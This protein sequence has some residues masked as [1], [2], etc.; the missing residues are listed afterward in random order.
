[1]KKLTYKDMQL[2]KIYEICWFDH[3]TTE[4]KSSEQ[5]VMKE[6]TILRSYG[7]YIG[8]NKRYIILAYNFENEISENNDNIHI[9]KKEIQN[10][11][12]LR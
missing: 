7:V 8:S 5:A 10:I 6:P 12:E 2:G 11:K 3:F 4:D 1:M 9:L